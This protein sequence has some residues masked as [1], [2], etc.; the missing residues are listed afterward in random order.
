MSS[1]AE[2]TITVASRT[3]SRLSDFT[4]TPRRRR[5]AERSNSQASSAQI[6]GERSVS[7]NELPRN[8]TKFIIQVPSLNS[9]RELYTPYREERMV[10]RVLEK[11]QDNLSYRIQFED[12]HKSMVS[13]HK[14]STLPNGLLALQSFNNGSRSGYGSMRRRSREG[15]SSPSVAEEILIDSSSEDELEGDDGPIISRSVR[16]STRLPRFSTSGEESVVSNLR[17][18][19]GPSSG[20]NRVLRSRTQTTHVDYTGIDDLVDEDSSEDELIPTLYSDMPGMGPSRKRKRGSARITRGRSKGDPKRLLIQGIEFAAPARRSSRTRKNVQSMREL[21][22]DEI[23]ELELVQAG[24]KLIG[25]KESFKE[26]PRLDPFRLRHN[27][28]CDSCQ[29]YGH[30]STNGALIY[31]QGCY[32]SYHRGCL[33]PRTSRDHIVTKVG[34]NDFVLQCRQCVGQARQR[35]DM[36]PRHEICQSCGISGSSCKPFREKKTTRQEHAEREANGGEDPIINVDSVKINDPQNVL[37]R[38]HSCRRAYHWHHLPPRTETDPEPEIDLIILGDKR[39][40]EYRNDLR[41]NDCINAPA[42]VAT[43]VAWRPSNVETYNAGSSV[44]EVPED[45]KEYLIKWQNLSYFKTQWMPGA[46]TWGV[47]APAMRKAFAR[48]DNGYLLPKMRAEDAIPEDYL[49]IDIIFDVKY[50]SVVRT[51]SEEIDRARIKE[52]SQ[53]RVKFQGLGYDEITWEEPPPEDSE[54]YKDFEDAYYDFIKGHYI[55]S[56]NQHNLK[57]H[58]DRIRKQDFETVLMKKEQPTTLTG[59]ELMA[60]QMDG[61]NWIYYQWVKCQNAILADEMGL[62]K[63]IQVI[64]FLA[65]LISNHKCW[66]F[67]IVVPTSTCPNW[68]REIKKWSPSLRVV[69]YYGLQEAKKTALDYELFLGGNKKDLRA[70]IVVTS[71]ESVTNDDHNFFRTISW[72]GLVVDE[73]QRLKSDKNQLYTALTKLKIP[74]KLLLTGTPLQNNARELFNLLQFLDPSLNAAAL[75]MEY[76]TLTKENVPQLHQLIRPYFLRR[77][78]AQVLTF[79]PPMAQIII[80]VSMSLVQKKLYKSILAKNPELLKSIFGR[81]KNSLKKSERHN[82]NNIL[83]QLRKCLCHPFVYSRAI[84]ERSVD[85]GVSHRNLV[86]ASSKLQLLEIMLPKL[87]ERGHR[88]LL[89]SQFLNMLDI[90]EDFLDGLGLAAN[91]LDG[92]ISSLERQKRIDAFNAPD[93]PLFA[94]LLSTRAGGVGIN[95]ATADTVII[96]DPDFNPHQDIQALSR[97]HRIG[98]KK[99]VLV[100]QLMTRDSAEEKIMQIGKRKMALDH[101]LIEQMD[102]DDEAGESLEAIL[103]HGADALF[104]DDNRSDIRYDSTSVDKLLDRSQFESTKTGD[105]NSAESQFSFA[106]VW[107]NEKTA[108]EDN[109]ADS[110]SENSQLAESVWEK[111]LAERERAAEEEKRARM[112]SFGRGKRRRRHV[113]YAVEGGTGLD[114]EDLPVKDGSRHPDDSDTDFQGRAESEAENDYAPEM[115]AE[116]ID[117]SELDNNEPKRKYRGIVALEEARPFKRVDLASSSKALPILPST[118]LN[119]SASANNTPQ[120]CLACDEFHPKGY[121]PLKL[122]GVEYCP[123]CGLAHVGYAR[124]CPHLNSERQVRLMLGALK[125]TPESQDDVKEAQRYLRGIIRDLVRRKKAEVAKGGDS[126]ITGNMVEKEPQGNDMAH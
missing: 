78:K 53:A 93:S 74:F 120:K 29:Q 111:I 109:L 112:E 126:G 50:T 76:A 15:S 13:T 20:S 51:R 42:E 46:W 119:S 14:L 100:F 9:S 43:L 73:G 113:D 35:D 92:S 77:T 27:Q 99:K 18:R 38:C 26:L 81:S 3:M 65:T 68:R 40:D 62:G 48:R 33:G 56:P 87:Q 2:D 31:C 11:A 52:V 41:C 22:E 21:G 57:L 123:L 97:A 110:E 60:Y 125:Q 90:I 10:R 45:E 16:R 98:Q 66:P 37:F 59:G 118:D 94:F 47:T 67:L 23:E 49:R 4:D 106:R 102:A 30:S 96:L 84:E 83:M 124:T 55:Y 105:D 36:A 95:L 103:K 19:S 63:T 104:D 39:F 7:R 122:A 70:H 114:A 89:F 24:P 121:C 5:S 61:L 85:P 8:E 80:P 6:Q 115:D 64:A 116:M 54:R 101:V 88:V 79:L 75:E 108:L 58:L 32:L 117:I 25:A 12:G 82:L 86:E 44:D 1:D 34:H 107:A 71:Y 17:S 72:A 91:R 69:A 28:L